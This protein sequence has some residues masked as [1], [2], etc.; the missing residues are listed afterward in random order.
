MD[1]KH[2]TGKIFYYP[3]QPEFDR[4]MLAYLNGSKFSLAIDAGYS[5]NHVNDF[6]AA[7]KKPG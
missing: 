4:P 2:L 3:N 6:Y 5:A 1:I 7:L